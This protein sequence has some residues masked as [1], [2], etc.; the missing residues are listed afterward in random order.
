M[1]SEY[2]SEKDVDAANLRFARSASFINPRTD[3]AFKKIFG[4]P[5]SKDILTS[6]LN[7]LLYEGRPLIQDLH[8]LDPYQAPRIEGIKESYL[9]VK[10]ELTDGR[11]VII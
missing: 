10:V 9:D 4:S 7:A 6:F 2:V 5:Q 11:A 1:K 8:I 3:F